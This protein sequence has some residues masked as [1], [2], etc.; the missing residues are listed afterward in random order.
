MKEKPD[1]I[2]NS[3]YTLHNVTQSV[4]LN[5][6]TQNIFEDLR[7]HCN[8]QGFLT[9]HKT[10]L[11]KSIIIKYINIRYFYIAKQTNTVVT[12]RHI[13]NKLILFRGQ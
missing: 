3:K 11:T 10:H 12:Q 13:F 6:H 8:D 4:L 9:C 2:L 7:N 5:L 1:V